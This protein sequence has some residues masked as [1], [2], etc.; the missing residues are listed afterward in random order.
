MIELKLPQEAKP[1]HGGILPA[2]KVLSTRN[3]YRMEALP[4]PV[5]R[6]T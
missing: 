6:D 2:V 3:R 4:S 5:T 1:G